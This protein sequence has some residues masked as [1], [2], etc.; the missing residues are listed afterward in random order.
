MS[1]KQSLCI[2]ESP[3]CN[4]NRVCVSQESSKNNLKQSLC[5]AYIYILLVYLSAVFRNIFKRHIKSLIIAIERFTI[6]MLLQKIM[7]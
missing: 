6:C 3:K 5:I 4:L 1:L 7:L 2:S